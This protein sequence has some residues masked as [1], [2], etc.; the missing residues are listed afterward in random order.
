MDRWVDN[1]MAL[2]DRLARPTPSSLVLPDMLHVL[3]LGVPSSPL[4]PLRAAK[5]SSAASS[6]TSSTSSSAAP[7]PDSDGEAS[8]AMSTVA[9]PQPSTSVSAGPSD[10]DAQHMAYA[11]DLLSMVCSGNAG[12]APDRQDAPWLRPARPKHAVL[13]PLMH[14]ALEVAAVLTAN[15]PPPTVMR[16]SSR[17]SSGSSSSGVSGIFKAANPYAAWP[18][19]NAPKAASGPAGMSGSQ[20]PPEQPRYRQ[21]NWSNRDVGPSLPI[22]DTN[23]AYR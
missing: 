11:R 4:N 10:Q 22:R 7:V 20:L 13:T 2:L 21:S 6:T 15:L 17:R 16:S 9:P 3:L 23:T 5:I 18:P 19:P 1:R 12:A 14:K 8:P